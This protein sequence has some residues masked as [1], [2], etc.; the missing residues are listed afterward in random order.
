MTKRK[1]NYDFI[2]GVL[3]ILVVWGHC[4]SYL[5]GSNYEKNLLT[6]YIRL[7]QMPLFIF[8]SGY[9][10]KSVYKIDELYDRVKKIFI[11]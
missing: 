1:C 6:S 9:F 3:I 11:I 8:M 4:C 5:S 2:K 7:F 10:V